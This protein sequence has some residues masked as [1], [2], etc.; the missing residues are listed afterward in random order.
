MRCIGPVEDSLKGIFEA[1]M[2]AVLIQKSGGDVGFSLS[3]LR[4]E[5]EV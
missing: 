2:H 1:D 5:R 3:K 4:P